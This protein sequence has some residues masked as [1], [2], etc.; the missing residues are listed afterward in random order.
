MRNFGAIVIVLGL[1]MTTLTGFNTVSR[2]KG[3]HFGSPATNNEVESPVYWSPVTG[4]V[5]VVVGAVLVMV[6]SR[7]EREEYDND[8]G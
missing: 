1:V 3:T 5:L 4:G 6:G 8:K 2:T 7:K